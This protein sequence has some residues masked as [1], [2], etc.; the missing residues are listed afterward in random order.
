[1]FDCGD[2]LYEMVLGIRSPPHIL[3]VIDAQ[4]FISSYQRI[5]DSGVIQVPFGKLPGDGLVGNDVN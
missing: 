1:M 3:L 5:F 2:E 4:E